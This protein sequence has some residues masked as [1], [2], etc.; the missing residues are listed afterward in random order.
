MGSLVSILGIGAGRNAG[1]RGVYLGADAGYY[2]TGANKVFISSLSKATQVNEATARTKALIYGEESTTTVDQ[3]L[4]FNS[5]VGI[6]VLPKYFLQISNNETEAPYTISTGIYF[7]LGSA[8][9]GVNSYRLIGFGYVDGPNGNPPAFIG[10]RETNTSNYTYGNLVFGTRPTGNDDAGTERMVIT[11]DGNIGINNSLP[12]SR[13]S[14]VGLPDN[15]AGL[16]V[17]DFYTQT[18]TE[19]GGSGSQKVVCVI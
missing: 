17:G 1:N 9:Y 19:L 15:S 18:A 16:D 10:Y 6:S 12:L 8:E 4:R 7:N 2:E 11:S 3:K 13:L 14:V 5:K